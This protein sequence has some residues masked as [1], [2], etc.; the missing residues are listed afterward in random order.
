MALKRES[1][2][3]DLYVDSKRL[4]KEEKKELSDFIAAHKLKKQAS[5]HKHGRVLSKTKH[6]KAA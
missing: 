1:T 5:K 3:I 6:R 2:E 4:T